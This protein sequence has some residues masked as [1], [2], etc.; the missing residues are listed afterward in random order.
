MTNHPSAPFP[1]PKNEFIF[2]RTLPDGYMVEKYRIIST[3]GYG[4]FGVTYLALDTESGEEVVIKE[5]FPAYCSHRDPFS[6]I[7]NANNEFELENFN[8]ARQNFL[9]EAR[10]LSELNHPGIVKILS[11]FESHGTAFIVM[12]YI[13][14]LSLEYLANRLHQDGLRYTEDELKGLLARLLK[15][16]IYIHGNNI[17]HRDIKPPNILLNTEGLPILIDF[18]SARS[19][20]NI[21][22][23]TVVSTDGFSAPEQIRGLKNLGPWSDLYS[24]G[25]TFYTLLTGIAP[26]KAEEREYSDNL[27]PLTKIPELQERYSYSFLRSI[28][29]SLR[30]DIA[31]RYKSAYDWLAAIE[32]E[33]MK[34]LQP[35]IRL[36][37]E[38]LFTAKTRLVSASAPPPIATAQS[39]RAQSKKSGAKWFFFFFIFVLCGLFI[40]WAYNR[41]NADSANNHPET[42][43]SNGNKPKLPT[44]FQSVKISSFRTNPKA[45]TITKSINQF[46]LKLDSP[47]LQTSIPNEQLTER[48]RVACIN[49]TLNDKIINSEAYTLLIKNSLGAVLAQSSPL[50]PKIPV[51]SP[52]NLSFT[53]PEL[54]IL[55]R[56]G[57]YQVVMEYKGEELL[58]LP[59]L[60]LKEIPNNQP[61]FPEVSIIIGSKIEGSKQPDSALMIEMMQLFQRSNESDILQS[62]VTPTSLPFLE[63][64]AKEGYPQAQYKLYY[65]L[66]MRHGSTRYKEAIKWLYLAASGGYA[67]A[68]R[69]LGTKMLG[70]PYFFRFNEIHHEY[71]PKDNTDATLWLQK[72]ATQKDHIALYVLGILYSQNWVQPADVAQANKLIN[73]INAPNFN[74]PQFEPTTKIL[75][76]WLNNHLSKSVLKTV[77]IPLNDVNL[78]NFNGISF[79]NGNTLSPFTIGQISLLDQEKAISKLVLFKEVPNTGTLI[80]IDQTIP[81]QVSP[82]T[83]NQ[84]SFEIT[85]YPESSRGIIMVNEKKIEK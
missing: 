20:S 63:K 32:V 49:L 43:I 50:Y 77:K 15:I 75:A 29:K 56:Q 65:Y 47:Y 61:D 72:A 27:V 71:L 39:E 57:T 2:Q 64:L 79:M 46:T 38:Q 28:D 53:F 4:G 18:G 58:P 60:C 48:V 30:L 41:F 22:T 76:F 54:P 69:T 36:N 67:P 1:S 78:S 84:F 52:I 85:L 80:N 14:G 40:L 24:L 5:N 33:D 73:Y 21:R 82:N 44:V 8:W 26:Q 19:S 74:L 11:I 45:A 59:V 51:G 16:L 7:I 3:I 6:G 37:N 12:Q 34:S 31:E 81:Q 62:I 17:L 68:Q 35:T 10:T 66:N 9:A 13:T 42:A 25:V 83:P 23:A 70:L 55:S